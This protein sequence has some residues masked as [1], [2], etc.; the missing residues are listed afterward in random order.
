MPIVQLK[1]IDQQYDRTDGEEGKVT[2]VKNVDLTFDK[3]EFC[4]IM[5]PSGCG[6]S[7]ILRMMGGVRPF[8]VQ[9]P[10]AGTVTINGEECH[11]P[12]R[13][14]VTVFQDATVFPWLT[15]EENVRF[16]FGLG[17]WAD[18]FSAEEVDARV[19]WILGKVGLDDKRTNRPSQLS[20]GQRQRLAVASAMVLKPKILLLDEPLKGLD[21]ITLKQVQDMMLDV[22]EEV[23]CLVLFVGHDIDEALMMGDRIIILS[24][25]PASV[26][27]D[28]RIA[29]PRDQRNDEWLNSPEI[30][31][32]EHEILQLLK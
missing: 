15:V 16:A 24:T 19:D 21:A 3:P 26:K 13:D 1:D 11:G 18:K 4:F 5:G 14:V 28:F 32:L 27:K 12:H 30:V 17:E 7:T 31:G 2:I 25:K 23:K 10:T 9:T 8:N 29:T 20:G 6:K 22:W